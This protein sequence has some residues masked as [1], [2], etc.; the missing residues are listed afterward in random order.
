MLLT[1]KNSLNAINKKSISKNKNLNNSSESFLL[2]TVVIPSELVEIPEG[3]FGI[4]SNV[5]ESFISNLNSTSI[6]SE[7]TFTPISPNNQRGITNDFSNIDQ[8]N[9]D[10]I[11]NHTQITPNI[12]EYSAP[13]SQENISDAIQSIDN[14]LEVPASDEQF[15]VDLSVFGLPKLKNSSINVQIYIDHKSKRDL[16]ESRFEENINN[17]YLSKSSSMF[18]NIDMIHSIASNIQLSSSLFKEIKDF[19]HDVIESYYNNINEN[20]LKYIEKIPNFIDF[21]DSKTKSNFKIIN[22]SVSN[23]ETELDI[24][25]SSVSRKDFMLFIKSYLYNEKYT[26]KIGKI[27]FKSYLSAIS[28]DDSNIIPNLDITNKSSQSF[29]VNENLRIETDDSEIIFNHLQKYF[30]S[31]INEEPS[32]LNIGDFMCTD[33]FIVQQITNLSF[34][35]YSLYPT[36]I[37]E[38]KDTLRQDLNERKKSF[39]VCFYK[40]DTDKSVKQNMFS[41]ISITNKSFEYQSFVK[42][43][44]NINIPLEIKPYFANNFTEF[45]IEDY[46]GDKTSTLYNKFIDNI[47]NFKIDD[48]DKLNLFYSEILRFINKTNPAK[49]SQIFFDELEEQFGQDGFG[50]RTV[51]RYKEYFEKRN[52]DINNDIDGRCRKTARSRNFAKDLTFTEIFRPIMNFDENLGIGE[53]ADVVDQFISNKAFIIFKDIEEKTFKVLD[54]FKNYNNIARTGNAGIYFNRMNNIPSSINYNLF[55]NSIESLGNSVDYEHSDTVRRKKNKIITSAIIKKFFESGSKHL[56][57]DERYEPKY[58]LQ[59]QDTDRVNRYGETYNF[60]YNLNNELFSSLEN[61]GSLIKIK[62]IEEE[63][64]IKVVKVCLPNTIEKMSILHNSL[65]EMLENQS[66]ITSSYSECLLDYDGTESLGILNENFSVLINITKILKLMIE[67]IVNLLVFGL[68]KSTLQN[69]SFFENLFLYIDSIANLSY[70]N[71]EILYD[72]MTDISSFL[73]NSVK[74]NFKREMSKEFFDNIFTKEE[75]IETIENNIEFDILNI[76]EKYSNN[77]YQMILNTENVKNSLKNIS[78]SN[79]ETKTINSG[80]L[81]F[82]N[83]LDDNIKLSKQFQTIESD[84]SKYFNTN[85]LAF[86]IDAIVKKSKLNFLEKNNVDYSIFSNH[87]ND[88]SSLYSS[89]LISFPTFASKNNISY[90]PINEDSDIF[91]LLVT[92]SNDKLYS[93]F[94]FSQTLD[95]ADLKIENT[96]SKFVDN[97]EENNFTR[98]FKEKYDKVLS[99][100]FYVSSSFNNSSLLLNTI[101]EDIKNDIDTNKIEDLAL[102]Y[103]YLCNFE[104]EVE[105]INVNGKSSIITR[106]LRRAISNRKESSDILKFSNLGYEFNMSIVDSEN[107]ASLSDNEKLE[108]YKELF[109]SNE[110]YKLVRNTIFSKN[111][112]F[113]KFTEFFYIPSNSISIAEDGDS[114]DLNGPVKKFGSDG[115]GTGDTRGVR[116]DFIAKFNVHT[117][118]FPFCTY[119]KKNVPISIGFLTSLGG[120]VKNLINNDIEFNNNINSKKGE[121]DILYVIKNIESENYIVDKLRLVDNFDD[122]CINNNSVFNKIINKINTVLSLNTNIKELSFQDLEDIDSFITSNK[123][124]LDMTSKIIKI[125]G[126]IFNKIFRTIQEK[127][128]LKEINEY[129]NISLDFNDSNTPESFK[130]ESSGTKMLEN[131]STS[132]ISIDALDKSIKS[133]IIEEKY[134]GIHGAIQYNHDILKISDSMQSLSFDIL[135]KY[136]DDSLDFNER[137]NIDKLINSKISESLE[138]LELD[139]IKI[140]DMMNTYYINS[141]S[142]ELSKNYY[143]KKDFFTN[144]IE[145]QDSINNQDTKEYYA[146][147]ETNILDAI[148]K[149]DK[150]LNTFNVSSEESLNKKILTFGI[151]TSLINHIHYSD[152]INISIQQKNKYD[153]VES[154]SYKFSPL[155]TSLISTFNDDNISVESHTGF[156]DI[157]KNL[158][159]RYMIVSRSYLEQHLLSNIHVN[160]N[161]IN[162]IVQSHFISNKYDLILKCLYN[163]NIETSDFYKDKSVSNN[164]VDKEF[165]EKINILDDFKF[166]SITKSSKEKFN[167][168]IEINDN[169]V[170]FKNDINPINNETYIYESLTSLNNINSINNMKLCF[171]N[172]EFYDFYH[173]PINNLNDLVNINVE[174]SIQ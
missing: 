8:D 150:N 111:K 134:N 88:L 162:K 117:S 1:R 58:I 50:Q 154:Y 20:I 107:L 118:T 86:E 77:I 156:Y 92:K 21:F 17:F 2:P 166:S 148:K 72:H 120:N 161:D 79:K 76:E 29:K 157:F 126:T 52:N 62:F 93:N 123:F 106:F 54:F 105:G 163:F 47:F 167:S 138:N 5:E 67:H 139:R 152:I 164:I 145:N 30:G 18:N 90:S 122:L 56:Q 70:N 174:F 27:L 102:Q 61:I 15:Y 6:E 83:S 82:K 101:Y 38:T 32:N 135:N 127:T 4:V 112:N 65:T 46:S 44:K 64:T 165:Y 172:K 91:N 103:L 39:N 42:K 104:E 59:S 144:F 119:I 160:A 28:N 40:S 131:V 74:D 87:A 19:K 171:E 121:A 55:F 41:N 23:I 133:N 16:Y 159:K 132:S 51:I 85:K 53:T 7:T 116:D 153:V 151:K 35:L 110:E 25:K 66:L 94:N 97:I 69:S 11:I 170:I 3:I 98:A 115:T 125:Y 33:A 73:S 9:Q 140:K 37:N 12:P 173:V 114:I 137:V 31:Y 149:Y 22:N 146:N 147:Q 68:T 128:F 141:L 26:N 89:E 36:V 60:I 136:I 169:I 24:I 13:G 45:F 49:F 75:V 57:L 143:I 108:Y 63:E 113:K 109:D 130:I 34:S 100:Y 10:Y 95:Y 81:Y 155:V 80:Y 99:N 158:N 124:V 71:P 43:N 168:N 78:N 84:K 142:K 96:I 14:I 129:K 48:N